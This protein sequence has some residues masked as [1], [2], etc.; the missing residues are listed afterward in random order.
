V[1]SSTGSDFMRLSGKMQGP[2]LLLQLSL[3]SDVKLLTAN[4][5]GAV[6][7]DKEHLATAECT[8]VCHP[9]KLED[10]NFY[11]TL[12]VTAESRSMYDTVDSITRP[13]P[14]RPHLMS[15]FATRTASWR[16]GGQAPQVQ[17]KLGLSSADLSH[18]SAL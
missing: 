5:I 17:S 12:V 8:K 11:P 6:R 15:A 7:D 9:G 13:A 10:S 1:L 2:A 14:V 3:L 4:G 16:S 18:P